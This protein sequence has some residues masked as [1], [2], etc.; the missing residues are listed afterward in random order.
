MT[1]KSNG[2]GNPVI[3]KSCQFIFSI[4]YKAELSNGEYMKDEFNSNKNIIT[5][6]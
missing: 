4:V 6:T 1:I 5:N 3:L 2:F